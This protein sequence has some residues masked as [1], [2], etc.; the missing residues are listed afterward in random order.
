MRPSKTGLRLSLRE[1]AVLSD[2]D[3]FGRFCDTLCHVTSWKRRQ[4]RCYQNGRSPVPVSGQVPFHMLGALPQVG[5]HPQSPRVPP[6]NTDPPGCAILYMLCFL[7]F[8][9]GKLARGPI[10]DGSFPN[11]SLTLRPCFVLGCLYERPMVIPASD[12]ERR[13]RINQKTRGFEW[14]L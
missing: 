5:P 6:T 2:E 8:L 1:Y 3:Y 13:P 7:E 14:V 11:G 12:E 4:L 10:M 9:H